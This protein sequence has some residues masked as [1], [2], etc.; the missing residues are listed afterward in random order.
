[1]RERAPGVLRRALTLVVAVVIVAACAP[2]AGLAPTATS[3]PTA[4]APE[5]VR[6]VC[7]DSLVA[8]VSAAASAYQR[9]HADVAL[10]V[11][12]RADTL[13]LR[14]LELNDA[15]VAIV[16]WLPGGLPEG[17][18]VRPLARDGLA[19][20]VHPQNGLP[21]ITMTQLQDLFEGQLEDWE[22][23]GGLPGVPQLIARETASGDYALFQAWVMRDARVSLNALL[24][25]STEAVLQFVA[26]D[27]L[28]V[29]YTSTARVD[30][31]V[32]A[33]AVN[34]VPPAD[35]MIAAGLYPLTRTLFLVMLSEPD[36][37]ARGWVQWMLESP[38]QAMLE[39]HG[40]VSVPR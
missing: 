20:V 37:P 26:D 40:L 29:G 4:I 8:A 30:G 9:A 13:A 11:L 23:W 28:A 14:A 16:T 10:T 12:P 27:P 38:G 22:R 21:G 1:L 34:G 31:R 33:V 24:A 25:P 15:D 3:I 6:V 18:W 19:I 17:V 5:S 39:A 7:P 32:R 36:G 2:R 35:E